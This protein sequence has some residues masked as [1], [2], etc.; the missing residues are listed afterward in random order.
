[1]IQTGM[2]LFHRQGIT[3]T[4]VDEILEKS[5]TGKGQFYYY[6][7]NKEGLVHQV[8][9]YFYEMLRTERT[10][11]RIRIETWEELEQWFGAFIEFQ[12]SVRCERSC[13]VGTIGNDLSNSQ[14]LLRQ[15]VKLIFEFTRHFLARFFSA[16]KAKGELP[17]STDPEG[18]ADLC[19]AIQQ[20]GMLIAKIERN[21]LPF[22]RSVTQLMQFLQQLRSS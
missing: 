20:G 17:E 15:D 2:D 9:L 21:C 1:M 3:A 18:L 5:G 19:F 16:M 14:D 4:S 7:K 6:F 10:P 22:E 8:L 12:K 13:P 11:A